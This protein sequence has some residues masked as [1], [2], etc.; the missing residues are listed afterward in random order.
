MTDLGPHPAVLLLPGMTLNST[1]MP[2]LGVASFAVDFNEHAPATA[3]S[4]DAIAMADYVAALDEVLEG[5]ELWRCR[6]RL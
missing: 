5:E 3:R 1:L 6:P 2:D 4:P